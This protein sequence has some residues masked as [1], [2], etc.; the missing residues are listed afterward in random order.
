MWL[1]SRNIIVGMEVRAMFR[2]RLDTSLTWT[3]GEKDPSGETEGNV[4]AVPL[5]Y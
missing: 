5:E 3:V 1:C 2:M 4:A